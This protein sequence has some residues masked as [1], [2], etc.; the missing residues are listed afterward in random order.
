MDIRGRGASAVA[1]KR[2]RSR[3][4]VYASVPTFAALAAWLSGFIETSFFEFG[5]PLPWKSIVFGRAVCPPSPLMIACFLGPRLAVYNWNLFIFD[6]MFYAS[7]SYAAIF[8]ILRGSR[9]V[10]AKLLHPGDE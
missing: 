8:G 4:L 9:L 6:I 3:V 10:K 5:F 7:L 2:S 1:G